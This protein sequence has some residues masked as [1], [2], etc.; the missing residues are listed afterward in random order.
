MRLLFVEDS[1]RLQRSVGSG[2]KKAGYAVDITGDGEEGLWYAQ[3][4]DYDA[5]ILDV[6]LPKL[7]GL[8]LLRRLR[9]TGRQSHVLLLTARDRVEDR[10]LGLQTGAD[11]YLVKPFAFEELLARVQALCRRTYMQKDSRIRI[12][13]LELD[14]ASRTVRRAGR[15]ISLAPREYALLE[16]L[17]QRRGEVV[18]RAEIEEHLYDEAAE[19]SSNAVDSAICALRKKITPAGALSLI[20]TRRSMGYIFG[21]PA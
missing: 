18:S 3:S 15:P 11:D 20:H 7:D 8:T 9:S 17:A 6:M 13:D 14:T 16:Y 10:V 19:P 12:E 4:H 1:E 2:L 21:P 5:I